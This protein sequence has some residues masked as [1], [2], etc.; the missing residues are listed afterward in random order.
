MPQMP[1]QE[2]AMEEERTSKV[3]ALLLV[4]SYLFVGYWRVRDASSAQKN[5]LESAKS[6]NYGL[7]K[8]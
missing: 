4:F 3:E 5:L 1:Q 8:N 6:A 2:P 7:I